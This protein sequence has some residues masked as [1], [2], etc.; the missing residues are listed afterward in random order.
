MGEGES[1]GGGES[2]EDDQEGR[3]NDRQLHGRPGGDQ[4]G[5]AG[6]AGD[7]LILQGEEDERLGEE[8][9][10]QAAGKIGSRPDLQDQ[11]VYHAE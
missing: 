1:K 10:C 3:G 9:R 4:E 8:V 7:E 11:L 2:C 6:H 5:E